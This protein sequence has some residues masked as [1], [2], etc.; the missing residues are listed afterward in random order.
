MGNGA[1]LTVDTATKL[2][3][4]H[5]DAVVVCGSHGGVYPGY[6]AA[7]AGLRAVL[8]NDAGVGLDRAGIG[9]LNYCQALGMACATVGHASA[10]IGDADDM[11]A[12]GL[13]S[14]ANAIAA[15]LGVAAGTTVAQALELLRHAPAW[16]GEPVPYRE[17][18]RGGVGARRAGR[19]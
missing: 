9:C 12:R 6:L 18:R 19:A 5:R 11:Q 15:D 4:R 3:Q 10:R 7:R 14:H 16:H 2:D 17:G 1:I 8:L 13:I